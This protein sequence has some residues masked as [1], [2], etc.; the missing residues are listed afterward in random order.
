[1][2]EEHLLTGPLEPTNEPYA[3]AKIAGVKLAE[4]FNDQYATQYVSVMPANLYGPNDN[5]D[6]ETSH[7]LPALMARIHAARKRGDREG[8]EQTPELAHAFVLLVLV[9]RPRVLA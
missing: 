8:D 3:I 9:S 6:L 4:A 5:F 1:M 2:R 7:V